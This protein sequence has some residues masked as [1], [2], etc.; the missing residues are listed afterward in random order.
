VSVL[1]AEGDVE[2]GAI[3]IASEI[4]DGKAN[5]DKRALEI[6]A[7]LGLDEDPLAVGRAR[8]VGLD[9]LLV[10]ELDN[11]Q[12][13]FRSEHHPAIKLLVELDAAIAG[14]LLLY[15]RDDVLRDLV[16]AVVLQTGLDLLC[17]EACSGGIP[18]R[19]GRNPIRVNV[20]GGLYQLGEARKQVTG[21]FKR[22]AVGLE[23]DGAIRLDNDGFRIDVCHRGRSLANPCALAKYKLKG[24]GPLEGL[25]RAALD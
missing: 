12:G 25:Q 1:L 10:Q 3:D 20:L 18:E 6:A 13:I 8:N 24:S 9:G 21:I 4:L 23:Q 15:F 14:D 19:K 17:G 16:L 5:L 7:I 2:R 11:E 22:W